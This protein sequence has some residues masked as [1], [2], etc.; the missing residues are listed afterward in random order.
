MSA[1]IIQLADFRARRQSG[2][3]AQ[4]VSISGTYPEQPPRFHFWTGASGKR[5][6]H[7]VYSLFDCPTLEDA[8]YILVR[9]NDRSTR[10]VLAIGRLSN[11]CPS[12]NL[13]EIR[14]HAAA[15][16]ADEVHV[17]LLASSNQEAAAVE[18]DLITAQFMNTPHSA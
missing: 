3:E 17:H 11:N 8:N 9:R 2:D 18:A 1:E 7:T 6:V 13:A 10:A 15:L 4:Q 16:G 14:Q 12:E 5:Y